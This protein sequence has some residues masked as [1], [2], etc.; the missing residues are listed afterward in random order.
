MG[1]SLDDIALAPRSPLV[2][3]TMPSNVAVR[4]QA[5]MAEPV[6][7]AVSATSAGSSNTPQ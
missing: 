2:T 1:M 4:P 5:C 7:A 6:Y 3:S